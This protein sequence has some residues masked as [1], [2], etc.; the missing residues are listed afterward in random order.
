MKGS[1]QQKV[2]LFRQCQYWDYVQ[3]CEISEDIEIMPVNSR[4]VEVYITRYP[5]QNYIILLHSYAIIIYFGS[6]VQVR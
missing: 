4:F 1:L 6:S 5:V 2:E 3:Q